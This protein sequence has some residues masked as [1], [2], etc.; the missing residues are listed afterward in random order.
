MGEP[1]QGA[2]VVPGAGAGAPIAAAGAHEAPAGGEVHDD[3]VAP[4]LPNGGFWNDIFLNNFNEQDDG[5]DDDGGDGGDVNQNNVAIDSDSSDEQQQHHHHH[6]HHH[7]HDNNNNDDDDDDDDDTYIPEEDPEYDND[8]D[9]DQDYF[10]IA[11]SCRVSFIHYISSMRSCLRCRS[12]N[13]DFAL[14]M[15]VNLDSLMH[16]NLDSLMHVMLTLSLMH[17]NLVSSMHV[18]LTLFLS[19]MLC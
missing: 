13:L 8:A 15:H 5:D 1:Q 14:F 11:A 18:M 17:V 7:H 9:L 19:C 3:A 12:F 16:V 2:G 10:G 6:H 4:N